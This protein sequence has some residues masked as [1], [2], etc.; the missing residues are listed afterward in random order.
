[1]QQ[2]KVCATT[3]REFS[4]D[5]SAVYQHINTFRNQG[6]SDHLQADNSNVRSLAGIATIAVLA[7][8]GGLYAALQFLPQ[9]TWGDS[10]EGIRLTLQVMILGLY[11]LAG[12]LIGLQYLSVKD[13]FKNFTGEIVAIVADSA[14]DEAALFKA[15]DGCSTQ[16]IKYVANRLEH[17]S[18]QLG[19]LRT[20]LLGA[21]EKVGIVPGLLATVIA[22][23]NIA[24]STGI[25]W[26]EFL[27]FFM[28]AFYL[29]MFP[30]TE[31]TIKIKRL[32]VLL[33]QYLTL[34][35]SHDELKE[36]GNEAQAN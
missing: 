33:N 20:F 10:A 25:S 8:I 21:I 29:S 14:K 28:A 3:A 15:F 5:L 2:S 26:V 12:V 13:Y 30:L 34:F 17:A 18:A 1:M 4:D 24:E 32:S 22:I 23:S 31:A 36:M 19:Q 11:V 35:R 6:G 9:S 27:S 16:A 7:I